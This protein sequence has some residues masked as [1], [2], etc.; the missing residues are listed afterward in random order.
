M[1]RIFQSLIQSDFGDASHGNFEA[2]VLEGD[3]LHHWWRDNAND[4]V[5]KRGQNIIPS[6]AAAPGSIIQSDFTHDGQ[7][8][9]FEVVAPVFAPD[10]T[11][12]LWHYFHDNSDTGLPWQRAQRIATN[13]ASSAGI[14]QSDFGDEHKNFEVVVP[15]VEDGQ[16]NLWHF[17]RDNSDTS[18]PWQRGQRITANVDGPA[19]IIQSDFRGEH[20]NFEVVV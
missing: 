3:Q 1:I 8:G 5:W 17:W 11:M 18:T 9:N 4:K 7:H 15:L 10:G 16:I 12:E 2:V 19:S 14:L 13:V 6:G 20:G